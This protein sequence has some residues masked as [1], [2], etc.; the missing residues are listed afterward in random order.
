LYTIITG[1][2]QIRRFGY[3]I[4]KTIWEPILSKS[5]ESKEAGTISS[6]QALCTAVASCVGSGNIVGVSTAVLAGGMGAIFW[7]WVAAFVGMATKYGEIILGMLYREKNEEG[8][9]VGGPMYYIK[10]GLH[11]PWLA[12]LCAFFMVTQII[13][14]N[15]IQSNTI[16]GVMKENFGVPYLTTGIALVLIIFVI[17]L[18]GLKRLADTAQKIVPVMASLY[19]AGGIVVVLTHL[20]SILPMLQSILQEACSM[21]AGMGAAA[22]LTMKEAMRFG[23]ARGLYSNE[24]GEGSAAVIHSAAQVDH[25]ARQGFYGVVEVFVDTMVICS[26]TG[27]SILASGVPLEGA[28]AASLAAEAFGTV[29]PLFKYV[30]SV[31]LIL[32]ASTSIMSQWYFGH[33]SLMYIKSLKGDRFYRILFP[34]LILL[35]S[36]S[37]AGI[38]W[39]VQDCMLGLLIIPNVLA[40]LKLSP[41]VMKLTAEFFRENHK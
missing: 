6:F 28:S 32:F 26:T 10:K 40:L 18:G 20:D 25:P 27:F 16:S 41:V 8:N 34:V 12:V 33:V 37:T 36:L 3:I 39:S 22:G 1:G 17:T 21:K 24:A 35:G 7:M 13:G 29:S 4:R 15:F 9:Y 38:V 14:G 31:S 19:I 23:V 2:I 30:V 11:A 5:K